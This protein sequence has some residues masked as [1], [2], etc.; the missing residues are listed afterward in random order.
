MGNPE[1]ELKARMMAETEA[2]FEQL[3]ARKKPAEDITLTEIEAL[4][5]EARQEIEARLTQILVDASPEPQMVP[6]PSCEECGKEMHYKG[7]REKRVITQT[8]EVTI[9]R[10]YYYCE[11][12][13][14]GVFPPG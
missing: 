3:L 9:R 14:R 11:A 5:M 12:C 4:V 7:L 8:G 2:V 6:G 1:G 10:P 13:K